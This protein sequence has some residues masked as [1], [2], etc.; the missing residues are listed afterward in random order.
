MIRR[1]ISLEYER[2]KKI[3]VIKM[4]MIGILCVV[5]AVFGYLLFFFLRYT[6]RKECRQ[7]I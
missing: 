6:Y 5:T 2:D 1:N 7:Q 3:F 4:Y